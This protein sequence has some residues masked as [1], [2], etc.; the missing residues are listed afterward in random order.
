MLGAALKLGAPLRMELGTALAKTLGDSLG[1]KL[2]ITLG[3][4]LGA[5]LAEILGDA[6]GLADGLNVGVAVGVAVGESIFLH[7][8]L[9]VAG[10]KNLSLI[11]VPSTSCF[12][13]HLLFGFFAT[14]ESHVWCAL[15]SNWTES[16]FSQSPRV[17]VGEDV[18]ESV[19]LHF[20]LHADGQKNL[21]FLLPGPGWTF[22]HLLF[23]FFAT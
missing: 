1:M 7:F 22:L 20:F 10:Q 3:I 23:G 2:G 14:Y 15:P 12:F 19:F 21:T 4:G 16:K 11:L 13:L 18:G 6:V 17:N 5:E 9:H 8:L